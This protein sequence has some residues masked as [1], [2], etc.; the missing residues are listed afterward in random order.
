MRFEWG[1]FLLLVIVCSAVWLL[2]MTIQQGEA[3]RTEVSGLLEARAAFENSHG[4][5]VN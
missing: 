1:H 3:W 5:E 2:L 4:E